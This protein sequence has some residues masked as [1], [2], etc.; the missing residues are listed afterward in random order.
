[1]S[2]TNDKLKQELL[3]AQ[4]RLDVAVRKLKL[5]KSDAHLVDKRTDEFER[6]NEYL[7]GVL[8]NRGP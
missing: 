2:Q 1:M 8:G 6:A 4:A 7:R 3:I 5:V